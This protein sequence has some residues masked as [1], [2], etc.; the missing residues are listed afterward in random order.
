[1]QLRDRFQSIPISLRHL[2][3]I[4]RKKKVLSFLSLEKAHSS[5]FLDK[6]TMKKDT[7]HIKKYQGYD[8][9]LGTRIITLFPKLTREYIKNIKSITQK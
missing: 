1:M 3:F 9:Y 7:G 2:E 6:T 5:M 8:L 4:E